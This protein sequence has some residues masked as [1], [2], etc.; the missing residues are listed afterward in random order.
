MEGRRTSWGGGAGP[1]FSNDTLRPVEFLPD[2]AS[3]LYKHVPVKGM[4]PEFA[5]RAGR[6]S[7]NLG[8]SERVECCCPWFGAIMLRTILGYRCLR[9]QSSTGSMTPEAVHNHQG[10]EKRRRCFGLSVSLPGTPHSK[11]GTPWQL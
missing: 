5:V 2:K 6:C 8:D 4:Q 11:S 10:R 7:N 9:S 1:S 3:I